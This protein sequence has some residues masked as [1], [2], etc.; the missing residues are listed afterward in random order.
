[1]KKYDLSKIMKSAWRNFRNGVA[2]FSACL[3]DAWRA[4]KEVI[5]MT[6]ED[7]IEKFVEAGAKR[8]EKNG[9][10]RLYINPRALGFHWD[11]YKSGNIR[12]AS[13]PNGDK[14]SNSQMYRILDGKIWLDINSHFAIHNDSCC[15][16]EFVQMFITR[17]LE[18]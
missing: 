2:S 5:T 3:K 17:A 16:D 4:A 12:Y 11:C 14:I 18:G 7:K 1:M 15:E 10:D 13:D 8:W 9:M 6:K